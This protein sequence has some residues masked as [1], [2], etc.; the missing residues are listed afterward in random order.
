MTAAFEHAHLC[1]PQDFIKTNKNWKFVESN[2]TRKLVEDDYTE[3]ILTCLDSFYPRF[4]VRHFE[5]RGKSCA[6]YERFIPSGSNVITNLR[7][8][9]KD[10]YDPEECYELDNS[11][12]VKPVMVLQ[13]LIAR[14]GTSVNVELP[15]ACQCVANSEETCRSY[16]YDA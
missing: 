13:T 4:N 16:E 3:S 8:A 5:S 7:S 2:S 1:Q 9:W 6:V 10:C 11:V 12:R 15:V 14:D